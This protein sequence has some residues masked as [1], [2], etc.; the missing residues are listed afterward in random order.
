MHTTSR[1]YVSVTDTAKMLREAL[2]RNWPSIKFSGARYVPH[3]CQRSEAIDF[4]WRWAVL[5]RGILV[6]EGVQPYPYIAF[7]ATKKAAV[8]I[9]QALSGRDEGTQT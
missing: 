2:R 8:A 1:E 4:A 3:R 5:D 6:R 7:C 9:A